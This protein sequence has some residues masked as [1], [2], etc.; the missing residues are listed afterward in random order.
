[1]VKQYIKF[2]VCSML[3]MHNVSLKIHFVPLDLESL[4]LLQ[5]CSFHSTINITI[6]ANNPINLTENSSIARPS[7]LAP[8]NSSLCVLHIAHFTIPHHTQAPMLTPFHFQIIKIIQMNCECKD[9][10]MQRC[11]EMFMLLNSSNYVK[12]SSNNETFQLFAKIS[13]SLL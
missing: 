4:P 6:I 1:M 5:R 7:S 2:V 13:H 11:G 3:C 9:A 8:W 12:F 10:K